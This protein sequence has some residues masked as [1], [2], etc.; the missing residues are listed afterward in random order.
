MERLIHPHSIGGQGTVARRLRGEGARL[1][2]VFFMLFAVSIAVIVAA[3]TL[4][5]QGF[6]QSLILAISALS[7]TGPIASFAGESAVLFS[8][9][10]TPA[11]LVLGFAMV[12]G[13]VEA[14]ALLALLAPEQWRK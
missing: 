9:L 14:L 12:L 2:W 4:T 3:L 11:K 10:G 7:T 13:R 8:A 5:G 6:D 1:A